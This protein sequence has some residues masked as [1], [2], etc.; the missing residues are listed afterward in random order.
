MKQKFVAA[1]V[2]MVS[3]CGLEANLARADQLLG[4]AAARGAGLAVLPEYFCL[5]GA[6]ETDKVAIREPFGGGPIQQ[7]LSE[8][9]RRH[10]LWL[11]GGTVPLV[12]VEEDKVLN[13]SLLYNPQGEVAARYDKIHLFGFTGQGES[14]CESN[15]IRPGVTPTKAETPLGDIAFGICYDL[16]FPELFRML[17]PVDLLILPA[18]FTATTGEAHWEPLLRARAI[19]N[20]CYLIASAQGGRHENGRQTHG[21]SMIIDPW[22]R[23]L[24]ELSSGEGVITAEIDPE[25]MDSVRSRL[26]ALAHRVIR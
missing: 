13:S 15:T 22:G 24:A 9:A 5:M 23:I 14:Y 6:K 4:E 7:A 19:E 11:L 2:Q 17:A 3:G 1:A 26:P 21:H 18:A 8:M 20:Q 10:G 12:C 16:R 25:W